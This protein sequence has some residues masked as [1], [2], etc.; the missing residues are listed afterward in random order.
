MTLRLLARRNITGNAQRY[1]AYFLSCVF[2]VSIFF[3]YA[4]FI[5]HPDV[6]SGDIRSADAVRTGMIMAQVIIVLF[7]IFFIA[8]SNR[9]FLQTRSKE[10]GLLSL[11]GTSKSQLRKLIY[12][13]QTITSVLAIGAGLAL[14]T[15]FS[16]LFLLLMSSMMN[17]DVPIEFQL[18]PSAYVLTAVGFFI[19]FQTLTLLSFHRI[20]KL[21]V[22]DLLRDA[23]KPKVMPKSSIVLSI[24]GVLSLVAGYVIAATATMMTAVFL[25]P[26]ILFFV[27]FGSYLLFRQGTVAVYKRLYK[28]PSLYHGTN[29]VTRTNIL[30]RLKDYANMLFL[31]STIIAVVLTASGT[32]YL[33]YDFFNR[34][35]VGQLSTSV[36]WLEFDDDTEP[37]LDQERAEQIISDYETPVVY[38]VDMELLTAQFAVDDTETSSVILKESD[39]N[40]V[41]EHRGEDV[42]S[43]AEDEVFITS[44]LIENTPGNPL[45]TVEEIQLFG[46]SFDVID[47]G[48]QA[49]VATVDA[50]FVQTV[51]SDAVYERWDE[52]DG[53]ERAHAYGYEFEDWQDQIDVSNA[54]RDA[55]S[56]DVNH[57][58]IQAAAP[59]YQGTQ[60]AFS[61]TLFIGLFVSLLFFIVQG[62]MLY[63]KLFTELGETKKQLHSLHRMGITRKEAGKILGSKIRFLFFVP[64]AVGTLHASFAFLMLNSILEGMGGT[65]LLWNSLLVITLGAA[66][67]YGYYIITKLYYLRAA[68]RSE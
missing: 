37:I 45:G 24:L 55:G 49:I 38:T 39:Y 36:A 8:Y 35:A 16:Y 29:L 47:R 15:L 42:V 31:T 32:V 6:M 64:Y 28:R 18:V 22:Q 34:I 3:I 57:Y 61:L 26:I 1:A 63:L 51:V 43:L 46:E 2:A 30:F 12:I 7:S 50:G 68:F 27:V 58:F 19:L 56:T 23:Q 33:T 40:S 13:E 10:F 5:F 21:S 17:M 66:L 25:I 14:G 52:A 67:Q 11:F 20:R 53:V 60:Q 9:A 59:D 54:L 4:Q 48:A 44:P 62:S 65:A 41:A